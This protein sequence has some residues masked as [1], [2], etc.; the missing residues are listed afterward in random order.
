MAGCIDDIALVD[1]P[2]SELIGVFKYEIVSVTAMAGRE[3]KD[4]ARLVRLDALV[5]LPSG[6]CRPYANGEARELRDCRLQSDFR[7]RRSLLVAHLI[8]ILDL[9]P[10]P[11]IPR[12][13]NHDVKLS[14]SRFALE[15]ILRQRKR[16]PD[17]HRTGVDEDIRI[18]KEIDGSARSTMLLPAITWPSDEKISTSRGSGA[19]SKCCSSA[20]WPLAEANSP[21]S[22]LA[23][24]SRS[25]RKS[26]AP[27]ALCVKEPR[28]F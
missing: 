6:P 27:F 13:S 20:T 28:H 24:V 9:N 8:I 11:G 26:T 14:V 19:P 16:N 21:G 12:R 17:R 3:R 5:D 7:G 18:R 15:E 23:L 1:L 2:G 25:S 22:S 4:R 10:I